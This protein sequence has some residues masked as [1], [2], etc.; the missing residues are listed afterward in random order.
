MSGIIIAR[1]NTS[2]STGSSGISESEHAGLDT[3]V[4]N[5]SEDYFLEYI[6]SAD[7]SIRVSSA[8]YYTDDTKSTKVREYNFSYSGVRVTQQ[9]CIQFDNLGVEEERL[10]LDYIYTGSRITAVSGTKA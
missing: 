9:I 8:T 7:C 10:T 2:P 6:Y 4:H 3:L 5:L 1:P